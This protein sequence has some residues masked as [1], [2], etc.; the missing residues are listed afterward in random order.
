V[1]GM[2]H[3]SGIYSR[4]HIKAE[5]HAIVVERLVDAGAIV[6]CVTNTSE[7]CFWMECSNHVTGVTNNPY[8]TKMTPGGSSG[9][10]ASIVSSIHSII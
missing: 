3:T 1:K 8:N 2:S 9:G 7:G 4:K 10:E 5:K 6:L